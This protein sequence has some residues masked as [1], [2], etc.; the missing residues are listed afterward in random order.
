VGGS[1]RTL[2][3][4]LV[5]LGVTLGSAAAS[6]SA[7]DSVVGCARRCSTPATPPAAPSGGCSRPD[8][9][10][11]VRC[12]F[13]ATGGPEHWVVPRDVSFVHIDAWGAGGGVPA[14]GFAQARSSGGRGAGISATVDVVGGETLTIAVGARGRVTRDDAAPSDGGE[15]HVVS[16]AGGDTTVADLAGR[17]L[18]AGG[19]GGAIAGAEGRGWFGVGG[20]P[21]S[22]SI[23]SDRQGFGARIDPLAKVGDGRLRLVYDQFDR[24]GAPSVV[25]RPVGGHTD[26]RRHFTVVFSEPVTGFT[27]EDVRVEGVTPWT[28]GAAVRAAT[29]F[30]GAHYDVTVFVTTP[31][32]TVAAVVPAGVATDDEFST[33]TASTAAP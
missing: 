10:L 22:A 5:A 31:S 17:W 16:A 4:L 25:V 11:R 20:A 28:I 2:L 26:G 6:A 30:D 32:G 9:D 12:L 23:R 7:P 24:D 15:R 21:G 27:G 13:D 3:A 29:P 14:V 33:N 19:G 8:D 18:V 1:A